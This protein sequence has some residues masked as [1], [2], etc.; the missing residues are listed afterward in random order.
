MLSIGE[1]D[2]KGNDTTKEAF[3]ILEGSPLNFVGNVESRDLFEGRVDVVSCDGFVG[4]VVLK[5]CESVA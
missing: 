1:E 4:N 3:K 2:A 5:T